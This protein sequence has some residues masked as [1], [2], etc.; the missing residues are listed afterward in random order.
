MGKKI[1]DNTNTIRIGVYGNTRAGKTSFIHKLI[2]YWQDKNLIRNLSSEAYNFMRSVDDQIKTFGQNSP[3]KG[4]A[5]G[6]TVEVLSEGKS[7]IKTKYIF[8]DMLGEMLAIEVDGIEN[9]VKP[10]SQ[11]IECNAYLFFFNPTG[12]DQ[13]I[14]LNDHFADEKKRAFD[15]ISHI[16]IQRENN[17]LPIV[18]VVTHLDILKTKPDLLEKTT[19]WLNEIA[20]EY[21]KDLKSY[22]TK[23]KHIPNEAFKEANFKCFVSSLTGE[24]IEIPVINI[25]LMLPK[26]PPVSQAIKFLMLIFV[27]FCLCFIGVVFLF[28]GCDVPDK[29]LTDKNV[30]LELKTFEGML[31]NLLEKNNSFE[32]KKKILEKVNANLTSWMMYKV[33]AKNPGLNTKTIDEI[34][35]SIK[36]SQKTIHELSDITENKKNKSDLIAVYISTFPD[37]NALKDENKKIIDLY[38]KYYEEYILEEGASII[39]RY[40]SDGASLLKCREEVENHFK[41][42]ENEFSKSKITGGTAKR[43]LGDQLKI[44]FQFLSIKPQFYNCKFEVLSAKSIGFN[45]SEEIALRVKYIDSK[46]YSI[47]LNKNDL[48]KDGLKTKE[49]EYLIQFQMIPEPLVIDVEFY[50]ESIKNW[51][52]Y[53]TLNLLTLEDVKKAPLGPLGIV[54]PMEGKEQECKIDISGK[55]IK[56]ESK[57]M[58]DVKHIPEFIIKMGE[59]N[60]GFNK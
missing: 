40:R 28:Q 35:I 36:N 17:Y 12:L 5:D 54:L 39:N 23:I 1:N 7:F 24:N 42:I 49:K 26:K 21:S 41:K 48:P 29:E 45:P 14:Y 10:I 2:R 51:K 44:T 4:I 58:L 11:I 34:N 59:I 25:N 27:A 60:Y 6:I 13:N 9:S 3:T 57:L 56:I 19:K 43:K 55:N 52:K 31:V 33:N 47:L 38:W 16:R 37:Y 22:Y 50:D 8:S 30:I 18:F 53:E 20:D 46:E 32:N 15:L